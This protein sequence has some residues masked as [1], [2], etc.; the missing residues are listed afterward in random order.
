MGSWLGTNVRNSAKRA[1]AMGWQSTLGQ[2]RPSRLLSEKCSLTRSGNLSWQVGASER[3]SSRRTRRRCTRPGSPSS[4]CWS[5]HHLTMNIT[6]K[7]KPSMLEGARGR[8]RRQLAQLVLSP[9]SEPGQGPH[10]TRR[11]RRKVL[12]RAAFVDGR[13]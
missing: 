8:R 10:P 6:A 12:D 4:L 5:V 1:A 11:P 2:V 9:A 13:A 3:T 7:L